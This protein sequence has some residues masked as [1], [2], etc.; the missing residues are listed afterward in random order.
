MNREDAI[1]ALTDKGRTREQAEAFLD[2]MGSALRRR[3]WITGEPL[4]QEQIGE[5]IDTFMG[6]PD[7]GKE[8]DRGQ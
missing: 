8:T 6:Q 4:S 2:L 7:T 1:K 5:R 3:G